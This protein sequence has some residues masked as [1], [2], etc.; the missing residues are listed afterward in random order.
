MSHSYEWN[1]LLAHDQRMRRFARPLWVMNWIA[2][3]GFVL[4]LTGITVGVPLLAYVGLG[5]GGGLPA[6]IMFSMG[7]IQL[8]RNP[9]SVIGSPTSTPV[10]P[11]DAV[12]PAWSPTTD[13]DILK[14]LETIV[15]ED[16]SAMDFHAVVE[17]GTWSKLERIPLLPDLLEEEP[18]VHGAWR[19]WR[20]ESMMLLLLVASILV[21]TPN[22]SWLLGVGVS[23]VSFIFFYPVMLFTA[24]FRT[25]F[26]SGMSRAWSHVMPRF[27]MGTG[28][29]RTR[30]KGRVIRTDQSILYVR[31][32]MS[33][34]GIDD[35]IMVDLVG[36]PVPRLYYDGP[37][38]P[39]FVDLWR[40]W[41]HPNPRPEL[42]RTASPT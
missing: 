42:A 35:R 20:P 11:D 1:D 31:R 5:I 2:A 25:P 37:D 15:E 32:M 14:R 12:L 38:D 3:A 9:S 16:G 36:V 26:F 30:G 28:F 4:L 23:P 33:P 19:S 10:T 34:G 24:F 27:T 18:L 8:S 29:L 22:L 7:L 13:A 6:L 21:T 17:G 39:A 40:R 41:V